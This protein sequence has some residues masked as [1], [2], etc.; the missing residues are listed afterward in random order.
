MRRLCDWFALLVALVLTPAA[1]T[2]AATIRVDGSSTVYPLTE[3]IAEEYS[4]LSQGRVKVLLGISGSTGGL[5]LFCRGEIDIAEASRPINA[6]EMAACRQNGIRYVELPVAYDAITVVIH[7]RNT[8]AR[9]LTV[10]ELARIWAPESEGVVMRWSDV[11]PE[12][13]AE[14]LH[15]YRPGIDSGTYEYFNQTILGSKTSRRDATGS[16]DDNVLVR[17]VARNPYAMGYFGYAYYL[18]NRD[19]LTSVAIRA[20]SGEAVR[21]S[22]ETVLSGRYRPLSRPLFL[23]VRESYRER[24]ELRQFVEFYLERAGRRA[25]EMGY[26]PLPNHVYD[27]AR[28]RLQAA[29]FGSVFGGRAWT[30]FDIEEIMR[31]AP[32][33]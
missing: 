15:L 33:E 8:W 5:R 27:L 31:H 30:A 21:P 9:S 24:P 23:Y 28:E 6:A 19:K 14:R 4:R 2:W 10:A 25:A 17:G 1:A 18:D 29:R 7:P 16:E 12:W 22:A 26:F 3:R 11:R 32:V 13:P 20:D